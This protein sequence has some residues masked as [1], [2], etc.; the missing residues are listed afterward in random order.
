MVAGFVAS[1]A[2]RMDWHSASRFNV[3]PGTVADASLALSKTSVRGTLTVFATSLLT[4]DGTGSSIQN[5]VVYVSH[6]DDIQIAT[7][8][9]PTPT[10]Y[11]S[12]F[13]VEEYHWLAGSS[14]PGGE[15]RQRHHELRSVRSVL[16]LPVF[17][18]SCVVPDK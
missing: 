2:T 10:N 15:V 5:G 17:E 3:L 9:R 1:S 8:D 18:A 6:L 11:L 12:S 14:L 7:L 4:Y 16:F 13:P